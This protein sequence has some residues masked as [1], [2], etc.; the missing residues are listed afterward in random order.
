MNPLGSRQ[1]AGI[2]TTFCN[3]AEEIQAVPELPSQPSQ[4]CGRF[5]AAA[6][7]KQGLH[8]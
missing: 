4:Q 7:Q 6:R 3:N 2:K 8:E 5:S 1:Q